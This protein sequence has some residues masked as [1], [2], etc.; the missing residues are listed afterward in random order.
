MA[1][2]FVLKG[3]KE[4]RDYSYTG[5]PTFYV[6]NDPRGGD[7]W[8]IKKWWDKKSNN[9]QYVECTVLDIVGTGYFMVIPTSMDTQVMVTYDNDVYN[10][11]FSN[12][13]AVDRVAI[14]GKDIQK[15]V[16]E[17]LFPSISG[18]AIA[19]RILQA[20]TTIGDFEITGS[21]GVHVGD[22]KEYESNATPSTSDAVYAWVV[23]QNGSN[24]AT[25]KAEVTAGATTSAATVAWKEAGTYDVKCTITS[26]TASDSPKSDTHSVTVSAVPTVGT[27]TVSGPASTAAQQ[28]STYSTSV[29]GNNVNDLEYNWSVVD[30]NAQIANQGGTSTGITFEAEGNATVQCIVSSASI[31][32]TDSDTQA[33]TVTTA[34]KIGPSHISGVAN[35]AALVATNFQANSSSSNVADATYAWTVSPSAGVVISAATA[36][37]TNITFPS[38]DTYSVKCTIS[39]ATAGDSPQVATPLNVT[40]TANKTIGNVTVTGPSPVV[41]LN[42]GKNY[43]VSVSGN[44]DGLTYAWTSTPATGCTINNGTTATPQMVYTVAGDYTLTCTVSSGN[45]SDSPVSGTKNVTVTASQ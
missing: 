31:S 26:N 34:K 9:V 22:N 36:Q 1:E 12:F 16:V 2:Q 25:S 24:V 3:V 39:S 15:L 4:L 32:D 43:N 35:T 10:I 27:V 6:K 44:A 37:A 8:Q 38:A 29:S 20:A 19:K 13:N 33:V 30:A 17:Y 41:G 11:N 7:T 5:S 42:V 40:A 28:V 45:A 21:T 23:Q 14:Y 18:G